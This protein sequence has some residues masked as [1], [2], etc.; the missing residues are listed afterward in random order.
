MS[1]SAVFI[2]TQNSDNYANE[3]QDSDNRSA[4]PTTSK[5]AAATSVVKRS[6]FDQNLFDLDSI[7]VRHLTLSE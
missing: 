1:A 6:Q 2:E 4:P 7:V 3:T 5:S